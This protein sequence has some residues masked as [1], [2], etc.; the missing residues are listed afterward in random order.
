MIDTKRNFDFEIS[1]SIRSVYRIPFIRTNRPRFPKEKRKTERE[2]EEEKFSTITFARRNGD[3]IEFPYRLLAG[4]PRTVPPSL[5][6]PW[7]SCA[8]CRYSFTLFPS[9]TRGTTI[10][11]F[12]SS[13]GTLSASGSGMGERFEKVRT[14]GIVSSF[15]PWKDRDLLDAL[16]T[17]DRAIFFAPGSR[18]PDNYTRIDT[19]FA[20]TAGIIKTF[21][22]FFPLSL[23][24]RFLFV[25]LLNSFSE[26]RAEYFSLNASTARQGSP[27]MIATWLANGRGLWRWTTRWKLIKTLES[28]R[29]CISLRIFSINNRKTVDRRPSDDVYNFSVFFFF[30]KFV[31]FFFFDIFLLHMHIFFEKWNFWFERLE[32]LCIYEKFKCTKS[33]TNIYIMY[34]YI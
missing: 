34:K 19:I 28:S 7:T 18:P 25:L 13:C 3:C 21:F 4:F 6:S 22:I 5:F 15:T 23:L 11:P 12:L 29:R 32:C 26:F 20:T 9:R 27:P 14:I 10:L 30:Y 24:P 17:K 33:S 16:G 31:R 2:R 8:T 1:P